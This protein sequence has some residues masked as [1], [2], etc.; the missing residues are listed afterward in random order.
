MTIIRIINLNTVK[1]EGFQIFYIPVQA[2]GPTAARVG[3]NRHTARFVDNIYNFFRVPR[4]YNAHNITIALGAKCLKLRVL[5]IHPVT[6]YVQ[7]RGK[8]KTV[9]LNRGY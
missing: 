4:F 5:N 2:Q 1:P 9:K 6:Y 8:I 3:Q 7:K